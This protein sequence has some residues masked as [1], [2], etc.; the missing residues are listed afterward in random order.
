MVAPTVGWDNVGWDKEGVRGDTGDSF[1]LHAVAA[2]TRADS[3]N[4]RSTRD[5]IVVIMTSC[6]YNSH[7]TKEAKPERSPSAGEIKTCAGVHRYETRQ[8]EARL[9]RFC[10]DAAS[11]VTASKNP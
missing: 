7:T 1:P 6:G 9:G 4:T 11:F 2:H 5:E 3:K 8:A 10:T